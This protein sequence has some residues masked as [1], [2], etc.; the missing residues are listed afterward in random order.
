M[1][2]GRTSCLDLHHRIENREKIMTGP[3]K[4]TSVPKLRFDSIDGVKSGVF[5]F[6]VIQQDVVIACKFQTK[7]RHHLM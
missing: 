6:S 7:I 3:S 4:A 5:R 2:I 1:I